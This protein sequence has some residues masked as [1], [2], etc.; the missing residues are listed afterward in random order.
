MQFRAVP[1]VHDFPT[2]AVS[3]LSR[4]VRLLPAP[5][6]WPL[7]SSDALINR[8][9]HLIQAVCRMEWLNPVV[10]RS[11]AMREEIRQG[12]QAWYN[13][14]RSRSSINA[15][16][17]FR[18]GF[19]TV[20]NFSP[21]KIEFAPAMKQ[22]ALASRLK[23]RRPA[24]SRTRDA[25]IRIRAVAMVLTRINGS[26]GSALPKGVPSTRASRLMGTLSGWGFSVES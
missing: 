20:N 10:G 9:N 19:G 21:T 4:S 14:L 11:R 15:S 23:D 13:G 1:S 2:A 7:S 8:D 5:A 16:S 26:K 12:G 22:S 24:L 3:R 18:A 17:S 25:G 6:Q